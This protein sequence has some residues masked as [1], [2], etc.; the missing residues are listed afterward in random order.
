MMAVMTCPQCRRT[1]R[2]STIKRKD[3]YF[4][5]NGKW[6]FHHIEKGPRDGRPVCPQTGKPLDMTDVPKAAVIIP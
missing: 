4:A 5:E 3:S 6:P 1:M 2:I